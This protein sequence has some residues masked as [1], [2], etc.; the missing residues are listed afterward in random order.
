MEAPPPILLLKGSRWDAEEGSISYYGKSLQIRQRLEI[1]EIEEHEART[2][3][4][5]W[6]AAIVLAKYLETVGKYE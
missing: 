4:R 2:G 5:V 1:E 6:D 3:L